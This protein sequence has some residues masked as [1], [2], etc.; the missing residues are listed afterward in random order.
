MAQDE[1]GP[2]VEIKVRDQEAGVRRALV[3]KAGTTTV[4]SI[5]GQHRR[6]VAI[7][8]RALIYPF[9]TS[10]RFE[11]SL[12]KSLRARQLVWSWRRSTRAAL[13]P[14]AWTRHAS[15][16]DH[17]KYLARCHKALVPDSA[18]HAVAA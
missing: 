17:A 16:A 1:D 15:Y 13:L 6:F 18:L 4:I 8:V 9:R 14:R 2:R 3:E 10:A 5:M 12:P 11:L 7:S